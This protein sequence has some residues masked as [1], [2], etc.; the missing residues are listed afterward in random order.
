MKQ[1]MTAG[2]VVL[3]HTEPGPNENRSRLATQRYYLISDQQ[4][5][6]AYSFS[7]PIW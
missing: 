6:T 4:D 7:L 3:A 5:R 1:E 2:F